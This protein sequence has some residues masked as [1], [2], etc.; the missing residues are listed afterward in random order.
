MK[1]SLPWLFPW[2]LLLLRAGAAGGSSGGSPPAAAIEYVYEVRGSVVTPQHGELISTQ[3]VRLLELHDEGE[4][5]SLVR[6]TVDEGA[7]LELV[8]DGTTHADPLA[9]HRLPFFYRR[10]VENGSISDVL[11]DPREAADALGAKKS[12]AAAQQ[13][14]VLDGGRLAAARATS[15]GSAPGVSTWHADESDVIGSARAHYTYRRSLGAVS[16]RAHVEKRLSVTE[17]TEAVPAGFA[18]SMNTTAVLEVTTGVPLTLTQTHAFGL[19]RSSIGYDADG[20]GDDSDEAPHVAAARRELAATLKAFPT[21]GHEVT[22][23]LVSRSPVSSRTRRLHS[24]AASSLISSPLCHHAPAEETARRLR[25]ESG[26]TDGTSRCAPS[27]VVRTFL[28]C[29]RDEKTPSDSAGEPTAIAANRTRSCM[30]ALRTYVHDSPAT[31]AARVTSEL[32]SVLRSKR[33]TRGG[34]VSCGVV[35]NAV[36]VAAAAATPEEQRKSC[37]AVAAWMLREGAGGAPLPQQALI[38]AATGATV[39]A[40]V[41]ESLAALASHTHEATEAAAAAGVSPADSTDDGLS[42]SD[43]EAN[44]HALLLAAAAAARRGVETV[45]RSPDGITADGG[46]GREKDRIQLAAA[47]IGATVLTAL[48]AATCVPPPVHPPCPPTRIADH[49]GVREQEPSR[50]LV[51]PPRAGAGG[52]GIPLEHSPVTSREG[53]MG[54]T[55]QRP[56]TTGPRVGRG[57]WRARVRF[58]RI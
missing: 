53:R 51:S 37:E 11:H 55:R 2:P 47:T 18:Y 31:C 57:A 43:A 32:G 45:A 27:R 35:V 16:A 14:V 4:A 42:V 29:I 22:W 20:G 33:C 52:G 54:R 34:A 26:T 28:T 5:E 10:S 50:C 46:W 23:T 7:A 44:R 21:R 38:G 58:T 56:F 36:H 19:A 9:L 48:E 24:N 40:A 12:F 8:R 39:C 6:L 15:S 1:R 25:V 13:L 49:T 41:L 3:R 17:A 30:G